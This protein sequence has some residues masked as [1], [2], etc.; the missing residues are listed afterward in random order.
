MPPTANINASDGR[1]LKEETG[2]MNVSSTSRLCSALFYIVNFAIAALILMASCAWSGIY[3]F[4]DRSFLTED[5]MYQYVDFFTWFQKVLSGEGSLFYSPAQALGNNTWGLYSYYL[6]SPLNFLIV[7]FG[8]GKITE[9]VF[10]ITAVKLGFIQMAAV[11]YLRRRFSLSHLWSFA[12]ALGFTWSTWTATQLR[13]PEWMDVLVFLPLAAYGVYQLVSNRRW[14]MLALSVAAAIV[15]CWYTAYMLVL[16]L[17]LLFAL[18]LW[19]L[20]SGVRVGCAARSVGDKFQNRRIIGQ[21]LRFAGA[22]LVALLLSL[23]TFMPTVLDM[24][25]SVSPDLSIDIS[26]DES[27]AISAATATQDATQAS[28][29]PSVQASTQKATQ[30]TTCEIMDLARGFVPGGWV[31]NLVP[32]LYA[33]ILVLICV[34]AFFCTRKIPCKLKMAC[35]AF[36]VFMLLSIYLEPLYEAWCGFREPNGFYCRI[37]FLTLFIM[38]WMAASFASA[39]SEALLSASVEPKAALTLGSAATSASRSA[40]EPLSQSAIGSLS[41]SLSRSKSVSAQGLEAESVQGQSQKPVKAKSPYAFRVKSHYVISIAIVALAICDAM[42]STHLAWNQLYLGYSQTFHE[43][44]VAQASSELAEIRD[45]DLSINLSDGSGNGQGDNTT[46]DTDGADNS[47]NVDQSSYRIEKNYTRMGRA[48]LNEGMAVGYNELSSY[49]SAH[50]KNA[51]A[52]L[53]ALGYSKVGNFWTRY[54]YPLLSSDSLLG[55]KYVLSTLPAEGFTSLWEEPNKMGAI[56][57]ENPYALSLGYLVSDDAIDLSFA[58]ID[59]PFERQNAFFNS[60]VGYEINPYVVCESTLTHSDETTREYDVQL[61][62]GTYGY[63]YVVGAGEDRCY[64]IAEDGPAFVENIRFQDAIYGISSIANVDEPS[65]AT[66]GTTL[67]VKLSATED[68]VPVAGA[69]LDKDA[70][71]LFYAL[72]KTRFEEAID[73]LGANQAQIRTFEGNRI[74]VMLDLDE[75]VAGDLNVGATDNIDEGKMLMISVPCANG[76]EVR[77]NGERTQPTPLAGGAL[78]GVCVDYGLNYIEMTF[79][80]PGLYAGCTISAISAL[81][82]IAYAVFAAQRRKRKNQS[83]R[84]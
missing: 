66:H 76:W 38:L 55:V 4:G 47:P 49:S 61:P 17:F 8:D 53:N 1:Y 23:F 3:P 31:L 7:F 60:F 18:E 51:I 13:N 32:Q 70:R 5:L 58:D 42:I 9:F 10:F 43:A 2:R 77:V 46:N 15:C 57:Y 69:T 41:G 35:L 29:Q 19:M 75:T 54:A 78:T 34:I 16:F 14:I 71:C 48:A 11:F 73:V 6:G 83:M 56:L 44:Y 84:Q 21:L 12:L 22:M 25:Q 62:V 82:L 24:M 37:T 30:I 67:H 26:P 64:I 59:N 81:C 40:I 50:D 72:D 79:T 52:F 39:E 63:A 20:R 36:F 65:A 33:G 80:P 45:N 27:A 74:E 68:G 28:L